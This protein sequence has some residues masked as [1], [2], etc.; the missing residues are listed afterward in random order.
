MKDHM[1]SHVMSSMDV[2]NN[3]PAR[4][5]RQVKVD[6]IHLWL[7]DKSQKANETICHT[8]VWLLVEGK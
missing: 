3:K 1:V 4:T 8:Y 2:I 5:K 6:H 7:K